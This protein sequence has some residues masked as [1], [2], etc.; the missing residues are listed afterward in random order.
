M[1]VEKISK[2]VD[3][4]D[5][6]RF[7]DEI[8]N[9]INVSIRMD[10]CLICHQSPQDSIRKPYLICYDAI[11]KEISLLLS[12]SSIFLDYLV[13]FRFSVN[14]NDDPGK[15]TYFRQLRSQQIGSAMNIGDETEML[16]NLIRQ[17]ARMRCLLEKNSEPVQRYD[18]LTTVLRERIEARPTSMIRLPGKDEKVLELNQTLSDMNEYENGY[19]EN[20]QKANSSL[21]FTPYLALVRDSYREI[22]QYRENIIADIKELKNGWEFF[23]QLS[24]YGV[25]P[26]IRKS[27]D[28]L[29]GQHRER[30]AA[31][32]D[33]VHRCREMLHSI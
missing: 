1:H 28:D 30:K 25:L 2:T 27:L 29:I 31:F 21:K 17:S 10:E 4:I 7:S 26:K 12:H 3:G 16:L 6:K 23:R 33:R 15:F 19:G 18:Y 22:R 5:A 20:M 9:Y 14:G 32:R 11:E 13:N 8:E 24:A